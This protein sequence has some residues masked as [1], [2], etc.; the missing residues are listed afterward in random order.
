MQFTDV[1]LKKLESNTLADI[2]Q[3]LSA[4]FYEV[5]EVP[6]SE[7]EK[8]LATFLIKEIQKGSS[9]KKGFEGVTSEDLD[10]FTD[11]VV[12]TIQMN[13]FLEKLPSKKAFVSL[14]EFTIKFL[15]KVKFVSDKALFAE[16]VL[17]NSIGLKQ[18]SF[19]S[20]DDD[21][22]ELMINSPENIFVF[23][24]KYG[25]C[26]VSVSIEENQLTNI[27]QRIALT[28]GREFDSKN[29]LLDARLPDGSRVNATLS[30]LSPTGTTLTIRKFSATPLTILDL[31]ENNTISSEA[32]AFL[33]LMVDGLGTY[34]QNIL[35]AGGSASGKT[36]FLN[37]LSN[38]IR[39]NERVVSIED[40]I[41]L[42]LLGRENWVALEARASIA[43][44]VTMDSLLKN[45]MRMRPDRIIVGEVRGSEA[46]TLFTAMDTGHQGCLGTIHAN[47]ARET[48][49]KLGERPLAVPQGMLPLLDF[50]VI[51]ER[52]YS[53]EKGMQR[54]VTQIVE[55]SR[56]QEKVLFGTLLD[57]DEKA[58]M[59]K[60]TEIGS[61]VFEELARKN[62]MA[63]I[64]LSKELSTRKILIEWMLKQGIRKPLEVLEVIESYYYNPEKVLSTISGL[65]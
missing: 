24:R 46:L 20:L 19:F 59:I 4:N 51:M 14:L 47:N 18:L 11:E 57:F 65:Q 23:H 28:I 36:T 38:F 34:P 58:G 17:H 8:Q 60:R 49:L 40:T 21:L 26:K 45:S 29:A 63:K 30:D 27:V 52:H 42:S 31:I 9:L 10:F 25:M 44:E 56:M 50:V 37:I 3:G 64:E 13:S 1:K 61:A 32:A 54:K 22:E 41:E 2:Y 53:K 48:I 12:S 62:S 33:W 35:I 55:L 6:F 43:S 39:L 5:K 16:Y 7:K 15:S